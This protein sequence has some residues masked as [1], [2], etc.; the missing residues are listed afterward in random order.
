MF[1]DKN[2]D[3]NKSKPILRQLPS[4]SPEKKKNTDTKMTMM[5]KEGRNTARSEETTQISHIHTLKTLFI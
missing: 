5:K 3:Q 1:L 2:W 4:G